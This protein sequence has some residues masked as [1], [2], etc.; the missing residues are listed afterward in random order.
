MRRLGLAVVLIAAACADEIPED[1]SAQMEAARTANQAAVD[2]AGAPVVEELLVT[3]PAGGHMTWIRDIHT[4]LDSVLAKAEVDRGEALH[5]VQELYSRRFEPLRRFYGAGGALDTG[6]A[7]SQSVES[8]GIQLQQLMQ[9]LA[10]DAADADLLGQSVR[11]SH[12]AL[13]QVEN[14]SRDAG[15]DPAAPREA[16]T[17]DS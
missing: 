15:L 1:V 12:D 11:A 7:M 5:A 8:A 2:T 4:G 13:Q 3:A 16:V 9:H 6:P 10:S 17:T 14:A